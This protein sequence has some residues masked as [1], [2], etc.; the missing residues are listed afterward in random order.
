MILEDILELRFTGG[1]TA[2]MAVPRL[3]SRQAVILFTA[4][5]SLV[6][7]YAFIFHFLPLQNLAVW[8]YFVESS[9]VMGP[10]TI[11]I[12]L[13]QGC[14]PASS[15]QYLFRCIHGEEIVSIHQNGMPAALFAPVPLWSVVV[16]NGDGI[17]VVLDKDN[18]TVKTPAKFKASWKSPVDV[19]NLRH[20][21][22]HRPRP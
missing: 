3:N 14:L 4:P 10:Q 1:F 7:R 17:L 15:V 12:G 19:L 13:N 16:A 9:E 11:G 6:D 5:Q 22:S 2:E 18:E 21:L 20:R 8:R